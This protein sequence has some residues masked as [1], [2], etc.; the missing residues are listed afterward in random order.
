M[1][2]N[3]ETTNLMVRASTPGQMDQSMRGNGRTVFDVG[4]VFEHLKYPT[5]K[6]NGKMTNLMGRAL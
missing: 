1:S 5:M 3:I 6:G 2:V 4:K